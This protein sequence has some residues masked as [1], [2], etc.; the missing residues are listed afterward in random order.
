M[1]A[2]NQNA[3]A[4]VYYRSF[5]DRLSPCPFCGLHTRAAVCV[6]C[7]ALLAGPCGSLCRCGLPFPGRSWAT[8]PEPPLCG[9]CIRRP[10]AFSASFSPFWYQF[11]LDRLINRYKH[12]GD[13]FAERALQHL[14]ASMPAPWTPIHGICALPSHWR[15][16]WWRGF[17]QG[18]RLARM[19]SVHWN[20][21]LLP[22][23]TR[24]LATPHQQGL[25]RGQRRRNLQRAFR[26]R[27]NVSG[28]H[29]VLVDDVMTTG[30]TARAA[31]QCLRRAGADSV[32]VWTL[33]RT[34]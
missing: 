30:T 21:P 1:N 29:L 34:P 26:C 6:D 7:L 33:A 24:P 11:P 14:I 20:K 31:S 8:G 25:S 2:V 3:I 28:L 4:K 5:I 10:P 27:L 18:E 12:R 9:R 32:R 17:D 16:R 19:L 23:L 15:R 13:L 22:A